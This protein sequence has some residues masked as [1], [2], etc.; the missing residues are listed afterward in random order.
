MDVCIYL[1]YML[2]KYCALSTRLTVKYS[3]LIVSLRFF[4]AETHCFYTA[5][6]C[7]QYPRMC[8]INIY[9]RL[10]AY[11]KNKDPSC[12]KSLHLGTFTEQRLCQKT[13]KTSVSLQVLP[14]T[15]PGHHLQIQRSRGASKKE[16]VVSPK[17]RKGACIKKHL[18]YLTNTFQN[19]S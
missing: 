7:L 15:H 11:F 1:T 4:S 16:R 18:E 13:I 3:K 6:T 10:S 5:Y 8:N 9:D 19:R 12:C 17:N 14:I 2:S